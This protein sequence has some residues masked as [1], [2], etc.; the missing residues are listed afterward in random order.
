[1]PHGG[2]HGGPKDFAVSDFMSKL[3]A[4]GS[5]AKRNRFT[6]E[7]I[8]P[9]TLNTE[10]KIFDVSTS[11]LPYEYPNLFTKKKGKINIKDI[12]KF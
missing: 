5:Y 1:M 9:V 11:F 2:P 7:I 12:F 6:V 10:V 8:P 3:D 4:L